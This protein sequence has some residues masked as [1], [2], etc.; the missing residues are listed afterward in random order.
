M[1]V[2][3]IALAAAAAFSL[4]A[5]VAHAEDAPDSFSG[6]YVKEVAGELGATN[7]TEADVEGRKVVKFDLNGLPVI[8]VVDVCTEGRDCKGLILMV[9]FKRGEQA[10]ALT[11]VNDFNGKNPFVSVSL[12]E[13]DVVAIGHA[14]FA[15]GGVPRANLKANVAEFLGGVTKFIGAV[16]AQ[17]VASGPTSS[18]MRPVVYGGGDFRPIS[19]TPAQIKALKPEWK[20]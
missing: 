14:L 8:A 7:V 13:P 19:L 11:F 17:V 1:T 5:S 9:A 2:R 6:D 15:T 12:H 18:V 20:R 3:N 16:R 10:V 4:T